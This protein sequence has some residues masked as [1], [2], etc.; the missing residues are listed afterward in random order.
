MIVQPG[1]AASPFVE[2]LGDG[3]FAVDTGFMRDRYDASYLLVQ[4]GRA[5]FI[6]TGTALAVPRLLAALDALGLA[7]DAVD[8]LLP[9]HVHL[10]HAGGVGSLLRELPVARVLAHPRG[11]PHLVDP[12][13]LWMGATQVYGPEVMR[14]DY[15]ELVPVPADRIEPSTDGG[16]VSLAGR[17]LRIAHTPGH[18]RHH[19]CLFD[20]RS[21]GWFTG[22][23]FG[24]ALDELRV[25]GRAF[26]F[27]TTT[28]IQFEPEALHASIDRLLAA[29]PRRMFVTHYGAVDDPVD[30]ARQ[31]HRS[32]DDTVHVA[33][34]CR[35]ET[36]RLGAITRGLVT[37]YADAAQAHGVTMPRTELEA[38]IQDDA[39]LNAA[40]LI[41]WL[42]RAPRHTP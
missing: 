41:C 28:P 34:A 18:A 1:S 6:D 8:W 23:T 14:R 40:G 26:M 30:A 12:T 16:S 7:R 22:D 29:S 13:A 10:D 21:H 15:R 5:A 17:V 4:D 25:D 36:D 32:I 19:H 42:D 37:L 33:E 39:A 38:L 2:D 20:E 24:M 3:V 11:L 35:D 27:P 9:T 31:L